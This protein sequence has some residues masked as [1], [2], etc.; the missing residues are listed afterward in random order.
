MRIIVALSFLFFQ[1]IYSFKK[2]RYEQYGI[3]LFSS[4]QSY[5][6]FTGKTITN[7]DKSISLTF[8]NFRLITPI[9]SK[10]TYEYEET[11]PLY[12]SA[13]NVIYTFVTDIHARVGNFGDP[14]EITDFLFQLTCEKLDFY[15]DN[16][17]KT[18][19]TSKNCPNLFYS[20]ANALG[21]LNSFKFFSQ[22][23]EEN[24]TMLNFF[25]TIVEDKTI[26]FIEKY[27]LI[28]IDAD[29]I[30]TKLSD[31]FKKLTLNKLIED[32]FIK[33][34]SLTSKDLREPKYI[35]LDNKLVID[36][37]VFNFQI[38][39]N[40]NQTE[41]VEADF[42]IH[43]S[44]FTMTHKQY[45]FGEVDYDLSGTYIPETVLRELF[46]KFFVAQ[47]GQIFTDYFMELN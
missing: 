13:N 9:L 16:K 18:N 20:K 5:L 11:K 33:T 40:S 6:P 29:Y 38:I 17:I 3:K 46:E 7:A 22:N 37:P 10:I 2:E 36:S 41:N 23:E 27:N 24:S 43:A 42:E 12:F 4:M 26:T 14:I 8:F 28:H 44:S 30:F 31:R 39:Y 19:L 47:F 32:Y 35:S 21:S 45:E 25:N 34:M 15:N 1:F